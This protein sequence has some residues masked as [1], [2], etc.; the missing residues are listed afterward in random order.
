[1]VIRIEDL[2]ECK[3]CFAL[4]TRERRARHLEWHANWLAKVMA[5]HDCSIYHQRNRDDSHS[6][7]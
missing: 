3:L 6:M 4:V 1:M 2:V 7:V 5:P